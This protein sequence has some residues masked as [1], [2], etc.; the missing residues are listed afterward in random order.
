[1]SLPPATLTSGEC[2]P[3]G[4]ST[5]AFEVSGTAYSGPYTGTFVESGTVTVGPQ[6][7]PI[8]S[9]P[10][11]FRGLIL[12][13]SA[14][15]TITGAEGTVSGTK[16]FTGTEGGYNYGVCFGSGPGTG[17]GQFIVSE[18]SYS[19]TISAP[20]GSATDQGTGAVNFNGYFI[21]PGA[22]S[23]SWQFREWYL[24][25]TD[26]SPDQDGDGDGILDAVD[27]CPSTANPAQADGD[28]DG[29]R[30]ACD[31]VND[32]DTDGD[33][34]LDAVDD[35]PGTANPAQADVD[36]DGIGDAC[37][38]SDADGFVDGSDN[39]PTVANGDQADGD[40]DGVGD[41][42]DPD[43]DGDGALNA[44][45]NCPSTANPDQ[46]DIDFDGVG[47]ACDPSFASTPCKVTAGGSIGD[48]NHSFGVIASATDSG[49][50]GNVNYQDKGARQAPEGC[51]RDRGRLQR[52]R[53]HG[54]RHRDGRRRR[55]ELRRAH[56]RQRRAGNRRHVRDR[57]DGRRRLQQ[58]RHA[59]D[60][61][62]PGPQLRPIAWERVDS[63]RSH[64][65]S[66]TRGT[67]G[68]SSLE[69]AQDMQPSRSH[70]PEG[71]GATVTG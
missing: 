63:A 32:L 56:G 15:F 5:F 50:K 45:D 12:A 49:A 65:R 54:G 1:M 19:A 16:T 38:D 37:D 10:G 3:S 22:N 71:G 51:R 8:P 60:G 25:S 35:C 27:N 39:C 53:D 18:L 36:G 41:A 61:Q 14:T 13:F 26:F 11:Q 2:V 30:D 21:N 23:P 52:Q 31:P 24:V 34:I 43:T 42:C 58:F 59:D 70:I 44:V 68:R 55:G 29:I 66:S 47:D 4:E 28:G 7:L 40:G 9:A 67:T 17:A 20:G 33:G 62:R 64:A 6:T 46:A 57:V 69:P 48:G